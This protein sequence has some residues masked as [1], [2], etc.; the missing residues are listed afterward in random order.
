MLFDKHVPLRSLRIK[1]SSC[2][3]LSGDVLL[4]IKNKNR[5]HTVWKRNPTSANWKAFK[6]ARNKCTAE[7]RH[8]KHRFFQSKLDPNLN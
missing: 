3:W 1:C 2:P 4:C 7:I 6:E 5:L 8:A